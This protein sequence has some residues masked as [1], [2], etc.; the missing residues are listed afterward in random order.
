MTANSA[1]PVVPRSP[2]DLRIGSTRRAREATVRYVFLTA[3]ALSIVVSA[4]IVF[5]LIG[6][7]A[8]FIVQVDPAQL[9]TDGWF[10]RREMYDIATI[11]AGTLVVSVIALAVSAPLGIGAAVYL[12]EYAGGRVRRLLKPVLELLAAIPSVVL[13]FFALTFISPNIVQALFPGTNIFNM[14]S[15]GIAVG[16]LITPLVASIA[17]DAMHA[18][19]TY[20]REAAYGL[21]ARRRTVSVRVVVPAAVS[22]IVAALI[23]AISRAIGETMIVAM[24]AGA[25][26][27]SLFNL[28]PLD[29]GQTMTAAMTA[30][31]IGSDQVRGAALT[32]ESLYFV[33][34]LLFMMTFALNLV[35]DAFVRR[36]RRRY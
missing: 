7:A 1:R 5:T 24:V 21:G 8:N 4:A 25:T 34:F 2:T 29:Q 19:P 28:N 36:V 10:P 16:I 9:V 23:L 6:N 35:S 31:A 32:F 3:A 12:S 27:G 22:G 18:V 15:A 26:G 33:G 20:L 11:V 30:L 17:E 13:G 14:L